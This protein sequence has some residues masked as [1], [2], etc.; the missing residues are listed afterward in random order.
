MTCYQT[1]STLITAQPQAHRE[2]AAMVQKL[3]GGWF[4]LRGLLGRQ[5]TQA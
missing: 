3:V 2:R 5:R 4:G 1:P